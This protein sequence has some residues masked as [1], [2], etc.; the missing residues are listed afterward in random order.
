MQLK[1]SYMYYKSAIKPEM[2]K[3]IIAHG[4][5]KMVVDE[6]KGISKTASTFDGKEKGGVDRYK[7]V[8][9]ASTTTQADVE[10]NTLRGKIFLQPTRAVEFVALDFV[11][12]NAGEI[13]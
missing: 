13:I 1:N 8:I 10:N 4:L 9:D 2:C 5:S 12:T 3:K 7:V 11:V 6:S